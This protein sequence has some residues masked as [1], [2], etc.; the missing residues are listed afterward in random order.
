MTAESN[1]GARVTTVRITAPVV[2]VTDGDGRRR[3]PVLT[4]EEL[5]KKGGLFGPSKEDMLNEYTHLYGEYERLRKEHEQLATEPRH[6]GEKDQQEPKTAPEDLGENDCTSPSAEKRSV[7]DFLAHEATPGSQARPDGSPTP[8]TRPATFDT[9]DE[10]R[11]ADQRTNG[12][13][14][15]LVHTQVELDEATGRL[16]QM[17]SELDDMRRQRD[18]LS[19]RLRQSESAAKEGQDER[20][21]LD[22]CLASAREDLRAT[23]DQVSQLESELQALRERRYLETDERIRERQSK[24]RSEVDKAR[25]DAEQRRAEFKATD[26]KVKQELRASANDVSRRAFEEVGKAIESLGTFRE[27]LMGELRDWQGDVLAKEFSGL[28]LFV[29]FF[30]RILDDLGREAELLPP[31]ADGLV[32]AIDAMQRLTV[33]LEDGCGELGLC[34]RW[35]QPGDPFSPGIAHD[36]L[37]ED[38]RPDVPEGTQL[39]VSECVAPEVIVAIAGG[40]ERRLR[41]AVVRVRTEAVHD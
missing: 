41:R 32:R 20:V 4:P 40:R 35:A 27:Q 30:Y 8:D 21:R 22:E 1:G 25:A 33:R 5:A 3:R 19:E 10:E 16:R 29:Q 24:F 7:P 39:Y 18:E 31:E 17:R 28:A 36:L 13:S 2:E 23:K 6:L 14:E 9:A 38:E 37:S 11:R 26:D 34:F 12:S 15:E